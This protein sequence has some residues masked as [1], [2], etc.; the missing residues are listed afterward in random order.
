I[1]ELADETY[2]ARIHLDRDGQEV[3][4]DARPSDALALAVRVEVPI[5]AAEEVL[6]QAA[7]GMDPDAGDEAD[8]EAGE[9]GRRVPLESVGGETSDPRLD[10]FRDFVNSLDLDP[11]AGGESGGRRS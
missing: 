9:S 8:E 3:E 11:G 6:A 1:S 5:F 4:V 2:H 7:L 10:M